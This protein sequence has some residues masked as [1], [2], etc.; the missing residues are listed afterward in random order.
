M[1][2]EK[3]FDL[4]RLINAAGGIDKLRARMGL[5]ERRGYNLICRWR[6]RGAIPAAAVLKNR[7][8]FLSLSRV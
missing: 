8:L 2:T 5:D 6:A 1:P 4:D 7:A 3:T